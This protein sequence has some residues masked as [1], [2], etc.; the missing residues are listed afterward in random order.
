MKALPPTIIESIAA[1]S[2][3]LFVFCVFFLASFL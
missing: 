1:L 3:L 2:L